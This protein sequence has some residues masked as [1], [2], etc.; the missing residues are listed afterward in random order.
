M[1][2]STEHPGIA[3]FDVCFDIHSVRIW[4]N[5]R[6]SRDVSDWINVLIEFVSTDFL[7]SLFPFIDAEWV[8]VTSV[9]QRQRTQSECS[10]AEA[11]D[12]FSSK[13]WWSDVDVFVCTSSRQDQGHHPY[14]LSSF[15]YSFNHRRRARLFS[16]S[17]SL[18]LLSLLLFCAR[19][20]ILSI[21]FERINIVFATV[22]ID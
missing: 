18:G 4:T 20:A 12:F 5:S 15:I 7:R 14:R 9:E 21:P 2:I 6:S 11:I 13:F 16:L 19:R 8:R 17:L 22:L 3:L 1:S 10:N